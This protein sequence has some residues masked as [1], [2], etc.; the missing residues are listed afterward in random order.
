MNQRF[1][2]L[3]LF[4]LLPGLHAPQ[5]RASVIVSIN[6]VNQVVE[7]G[8]TFEVNIMAD[9][10]E[11]VLGWGLDLFT[12]L[13]GL[14][15]ITGLPTIGPN[16]LS[17]PAPDG[18][19]LAGLAFP[20][21]V[22]GSGILLATAMFSA[23]AVG[24]SDLLLSTSPGD[25]NEGFALVDGGFADVTFEFGHFSII[26]PP[27][28]VVVRFDPRLQTV[29]LGDIF[30]VDIV[31]DIGVPILGWG[32]DLLIESAGIVSLDSPPAI[33]PDWLSVFAADGDG[34]AGLA[35]P[36]P[37]VGNDI[38]LGSLTFAADAIGQADLSLA[39]TAGDLTEGFALDSEGFAELLFESGNVTVVPEPATLA[40][41]L[42]GGLGLMRRRRAQ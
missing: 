16:W 17:A 5:S 4:A 26:P 7:R 38:V 15:S 14:A 10:D 20:N 27:P 22:V 23:D 12:S 37:V 13:P 32:L 39:T 18:D 31:A 3:C 19:G 9:I 6:P 30:T 8:D 28:D 40:L 2:G 25:L 42:L 1:F 36:D 33:G 41:C 34:L 11:P 29:E 21:P 35:F 24:E